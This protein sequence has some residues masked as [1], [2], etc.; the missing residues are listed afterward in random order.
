MG[1]RAQSRQ[2]EEALAR[3]AADEAGQG[4]LPGGRAMVGREELEAPATCSPAAPTLN[5]G[6]S[7]TCCWQTQGPW[8]STLSGEAGVPRGPLNASEHFRQQTP[9]GHAPLGEIHSLPVGSGRHWASA[10]GRKWYFASRECL[11]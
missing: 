4:L 9:L 2:Q 5:A 1:C 7:R 3:A 8:A 11:G 6:T 10:A